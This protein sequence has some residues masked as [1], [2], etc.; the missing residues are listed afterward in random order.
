MELFG[1]VFSWLIIF[2]KKLKRRGRE[3]VKLM[4]ISYGKVTYCHGKVM[5]IHYLI[6]VGTLSDAELVNSAGVSGFVSDHCALHTSLVCTRSHPKRKKITFRLFI[7]IYCLLIMV[8]SILTLILKKL[9]R[10]LT[11]ITLFLLH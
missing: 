8:K 10:L 11:I 1:S 2:V 6:Y 4:I 3:R 5:E 7:M 9:I